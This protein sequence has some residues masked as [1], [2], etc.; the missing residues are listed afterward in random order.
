MS[1]DET[2]NQRL[3]RLAF[4]ARAVVAQQSAHGKWR[5]SIPPQSDDSDMVICDLASAAEEAAT[6]AAPQATAEA[7]ALRSEP[8]I[9]EI[10]ARMKQAIYFHS[11]DDMTYLLSALAAARREIA[12]VRNDLAACRRI[13]N[14]RYQHGWDD[15]LLAGKPKR[16][17]LKAAL[18][19]FVNLA[20]DV[21]KAGGKPE[22]DE[23]EAA[24]VAGEAALLAVEQGEST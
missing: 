11:W 8:R 6:V 1:N 14:D 3:L 22:P 24:T 18:T 5:M 13:A 9:A 17:A 21:G 7:D 16:D 2:L 19:W 10:Q 4:K 20:H 23:W 12:E 15:A